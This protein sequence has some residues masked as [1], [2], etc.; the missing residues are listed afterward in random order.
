MNQPLSPLESQL[1][2]LNHHIAILSDASGIFRMALSGHRT[3]LQELL[4]TVRSGDADAL[5]NKKNIDALRT[6]VH[7]VIDNIRSGNKFGT[8]QY[9]EGQEIW[10]THGPAT[11][12]KIYTFKGTY[13][14][15]VEFDHGGPMRKVSGPNLKDSLLDP[16]DN[17][18]LFERDKEICVEI[19]KFIESLDVNLVEQ[20]SPLIEWDLN[21]VPAAQ[22]LEFLQTQFD[23]SDEEV[24]LQKAKDCLAS[25][26]DSKKMRTIR[27]AIKGAATVGRFALLAGEISIEQLKEQSLK[28]AIHMAAQYSFEEAYQ[29]L[30]NILRSQGQQQDED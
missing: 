18:E 27:N 22:C 28:A 6:D 17:R 1:I 29:S 15:N 21:S 14:L 11:I 19:K 9:A 26:L 23:W 2:E 16:D 13:Q 4:H 30:F 10:T 24:F 25:S 3:T 7:T 8:L 20:I 12:T 5:T